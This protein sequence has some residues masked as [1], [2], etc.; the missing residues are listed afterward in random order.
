MSDRSQSRSPLG[1]HTKHSR[2]ETTEA[3]AAGRQIEIPFGRLGECDRR[4]RPEFF[5]VLDVAI[6]AVAHLTRMRCR[7]NAAMAERSRSE[8]ARTLHPANDA[9]GVEVV[10]CSFDQARIG[11]LFDVLAILSRRSQQILRVHS[12]APEW[13]IRHVPI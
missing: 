6:E 5:A 10:R 8:L 4:E 2:H 13:M 12:R 11:Q 1:P 9:A 3:R 7:E